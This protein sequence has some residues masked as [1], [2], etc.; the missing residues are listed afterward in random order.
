MTGGAGAP[1]R[2]ALAGGGTGGHLVPALNLLAWGSERGRVDALLWFVTGRAVERRVLGDLSARLGVP[3]TVSDQGLEGRRRA[4]GRVRQAFDLP[5]AVLRARRELASFRADVLLGTGG[6]GSTPGVLAARSLGVP[7]VLLEVN[8]RAGSAV[9]YL[10][11][12][13]ARVCHSLRGS[14]PTAGSTRHV[15]TGPPEPPTGAPI[16]SNAAPAANARPR[17]L[18]LGGSQGAGAL[19]AFVRDAAP[20]L[21][22]A[23]IDVVHQVG[24]QRLDEGAAASAGYRAVEYLDDV[25]DELAR[26]DVVLC[27]GGAATMVE[28]AAARCPAL[29]VPYPHHTDRHQE[30]NARELGDGARVIDEARLTNERAAVESELVG[31]LGPDGSRERDRMRAALAGAIRPGGSAAIFELFEALRAER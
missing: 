23:G 7:V 3:A 21:V 27:R 13:A 2:I 20:R 15:W 26:A 30:H 24:P 11:P 8:A 14:R 17:L 12:L 10:A 16:G 5:R 19:N 29:V 28:V 9:R 18:V 4:P 22:A 31:L 6:F 25:P 1:V